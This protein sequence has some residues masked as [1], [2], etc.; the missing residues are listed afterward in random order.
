MNPIVTEITRRGR[1]SF[2]EFMELALY[3]PAAGFYTRPRVGPGPAGERGDFITAPTAG[4]ILARTLARIARELSRAVGEPLVFA[5]LGAG[6]G[7]L[8]ERL[9]E[10]LGETRESTVRRIVAVEVAGWAR[11]RIEGRC[12]GAEAVRRLWD[13]PLPSGP[14]LLFA[15]ELYDAVPAHRVTVRRRNGEVELAEYYV[16]ARPGGSLAWT[17]DAPSSEVIAGYLAARNVVL[18]EGQ[19]AEVRPGLES[20]HAQ[21]LG[22]C[23]R[24]AVALFIDYGFSSHRLYNPRARRGGSLAGY[25]G[26]RLVED[27][28]ADP[29][30]VDV[31]AHVNVDDLDVAAAG[32]GWERAE[33]RPLGAFLALHGAI[34]LLPPAISSAGELTAAEWAELGEAKRL[35]APSGMGGDLKVFAQG[36]GLAWQAYVKLATPPPVEA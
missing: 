27:V 26:H 9:C 1:V 22:W 19:I 4:H 29:G 14:V 17:L 11:E 3:H 20:L 8:L 35:L 16:E 30:E 25:R 23:A 2:A 18:E 10:A 5:E 24:S 32:M 34:E 33:P 36:K 6:E 13:A 28:L 15:S 21:H 12:P 7:L 31:T